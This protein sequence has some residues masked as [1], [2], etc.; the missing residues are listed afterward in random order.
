[1]CHIYLKVRA[2][3]FGIAELNC[4]IWGEDPARKAVTRQYYVFPQR[5]SDA[6][7]ER[8]QPCFVAHS[9]VAPEP[10]ATAFCYSFAHQTR[11]RE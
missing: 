1:M 10:S 3:A 5:A 9:E 4:L 2:K 6:L 11:R 7:A 8:R